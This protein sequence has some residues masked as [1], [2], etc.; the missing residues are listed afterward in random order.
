VKA[1][2][3]IFQKQIESLSTDLDEIQSMRARASGKVV[4]S[5]DAHRTSSNHLLR[6]AFNQPE[7]KLELNSDY[8]FCSSDE[9]YQKPS[10]SSGSLN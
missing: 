7:T 9:I 4:G 1:E 5:N 3:K 2:S 8:K 10:N 6:E